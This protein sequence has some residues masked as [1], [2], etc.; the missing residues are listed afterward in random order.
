MAMSGKWSI[1]TDQERY[2]GEWD[3]KEEAIAEAQTYDQTCWVGQCVPPVPPE[4]L[5]N[6]YSVATWLDCD[7]L[8]HDDYAGEWAEGSVQA[9][10]EQRDELAAEIRPI[11]AAWLDRHKLRPKHWSIDPNTVE[12]VTM[13]DA[14]DVL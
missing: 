12:E 9:T 8:Q 4:N 10:R 5:F 14:P 3:T 2:H 13:E 7:V 6:G 1:S 11:I